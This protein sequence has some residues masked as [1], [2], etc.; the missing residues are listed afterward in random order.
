[1]PCF[2]S[3]GA[4]ARLPEEA[5]AVL[6]FFGGANLG[7][8]VVLG[9]VSIGDNQTLRD[10]VQAVL[11]DTAERTTLAV[12]Q[13]LLLQ[14]DL[15]DKSTFFTVLDALDVQSPGGQQTKGQSPGG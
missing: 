1:M 2:I 10:V 14:I 6:G 8:P 9:K 13:S 12:A 4:P 3:R 11:A 7:L 5:S 15:G